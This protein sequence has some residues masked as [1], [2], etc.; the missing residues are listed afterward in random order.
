M[1][2]TQEIIPPMQPGVDHPQHIK[3]TRQAIAEKVG[4]RVA[5]VTPSEEVA[6]NIVDAGTTEFLE[7]V[8]HTGSKPTDRL[9]E[10]AATNSFGD[11]MKE[12]QA[13]IPGG[14]TDRTTPSGDFSEL[15]E[16]RQE[17]MTKF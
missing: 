10:T 8:T 6:K 14:D 12:V 15:E 11:F 16:K 4:V 9:P 5:D 1:T 2:D 13:Y 7:K 3:E 17:K